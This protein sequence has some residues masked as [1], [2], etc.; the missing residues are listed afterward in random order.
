MKKRWLLFLMVAMA[1]NSLAA[2]DFRI[3][4]G[5][6][7]TLRCDTAAMEP[8]VRSALQMLRNDLREVFGIELVTVKE[9]DGA[10][11]GS[12]IVKLCEKYGRNCVEPV[13]AYVKTMVDAVN[14]CND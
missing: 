7:M 3:R 12:A 1:C 10:I 5:V 11:V 8:V 9:S 4:R 13:A 6:D 14:H 2:H